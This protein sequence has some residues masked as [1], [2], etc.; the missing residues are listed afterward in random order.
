MKEYNI[1]LEQTQAIKTSE[2]LDESI[3]QVEVKAL[4]DIIKQELD[5]ICG[6]IYHRGNESNIV[7]VRLKASY[8]MAINGIGFAVQGLENGL[9]MAK[10]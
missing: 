7:R 2:A 10:A 4:L 5:S 8:T 9:Q 3:R 6:S 1:S